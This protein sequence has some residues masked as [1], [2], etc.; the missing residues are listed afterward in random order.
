MFSERQRFDLSDI[1]NEDNERNKAK[2]KGLNVSVSKDDT[3]I[4]EKEV[5]L[6]WYSIQLL[7][8]FGEK[9]LNF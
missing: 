2:K 5:K 3:E 4:F 9:S 1:S 7:A 6:C 8:K